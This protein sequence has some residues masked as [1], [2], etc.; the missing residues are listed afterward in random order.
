MGSRGTSGVITDVSETSSCPWLP[1][2][3]NSYRVFR[4]KFYTIFL[5]L[6]LVLQAPHNLYFLKF[7]D[8]E[9]S[10]SIP[11]ATRFSE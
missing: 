1:Q 2:V 8:T 9:I 11:G 6:I 3:P 7:K 4:P 10:G 5:R